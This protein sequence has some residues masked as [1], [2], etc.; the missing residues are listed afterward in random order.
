MSVGRCQ[1]VGV[2][3]STSFFFLG[4]A[5][6]VS[7]EVRLSSNARRIGLPSLVVFIAFST[8]PMDVRRRGYLWGKLY[9]ISGSSR[10]HVN[11][12]NPEILF[13]EILFTTYSVTTAANEIDLTVE[14]LG[15]SIDWKVSAVGL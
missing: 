14:S 7:T 1:S 6:P 12:E 5:K 4:L 10:L 3:L 11:P 9:R 8:R 2:P 15:A 13:T